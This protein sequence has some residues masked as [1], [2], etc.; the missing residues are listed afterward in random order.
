MEFSFLTVE[1][2][3]AIGWSLVHSIWQILVIA[4]VLKTVLLISRKN[5]P[6]LKFNFMLASLVFSLVSF[7]ITFFV[8]YTPAAV[9]TAVVNTSKLIVPNIVFASQPQSVL[10]TITSFIDAHVNTIVFIWLI[11]IM[12]Y[13]L[14]IVFGFLYVENI[15]RNSTPINDKTFIQLFEKLCQR[16]G[17]LRCVKVLESMTVKVPMVMGHLK[18]V[19]LLPAGLLTGMPYNQ[20]EAIMAHELAHI[21]RRDFLVNIIVVVIESLFFYHP[22]IWWITSAMDDEREKCCDDIAVKITGSKLIYAKALTSVIEKSIAKPQMALALSSNKQ[23]LYLRISRLLKDN[24]MKSNLREKMI[25]PIALLLVISTLAFASNVNKPNSTLQNALLDASANI[26]KQVDKEKE[27]YHYSFGL[28]DSTSLK[29][30]NGS[31][32]T[33]T[34]NSGFT[35]SRTGTYKCSSDNIVH[36]SESQNFVCIEGNS[37]G[38]SVMA[39]LD[40]DKLSHLEINSEIIDQKDYYKYK[41]VVDKCVK[42]ALAS[43][44]NR[45]V[46]PYRVNND[47]SFGSDNN[48]LNVQKTHTSTVGVTDGKKSSSSSSQLVKVIAKDDSNIVRKVSEDIEANNVIYIDDQSGSMVIKG[49]SF[50]VDSVDYFSNASQYTSITHKINDKN[51]LLVLNGSSV[52]KLKINGK[53]IPE[54]DYQKYKHLVDECIDK[55]DDIVK[56]EEK[57]SSLCELST[58]SDENIFYSSAHNDSYLYLNKTIKGERVKV[59]IDGNTVKKLEVNGKVIPESEYKNH[60][61]LIKECIE[62]SVMSEKEIRDVEK[63]LIDVKEDLSNTEI[64]LKEIEE[65]IEEAQISLNKD[66]KNI[67]LNLNITSE[68]DL[69]KLRKELERVKNIKVMSSGNSTNEEN[70]DID[71]EAIMSSVEFAMKNLDID[72]IVGD[73]TLS[74]DNVSEIKSNIDFNEISLSVKKA[75]KEINTDKIIVQVNNRNNKIKAIDIKELEKDI[76]KKAKK[77]K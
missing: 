71:V 1:F 56:E 4:I 30:A 63:D 51:V 31:S 74:L 16:I 17:I 61:K 65:D 26:D 75:G 53:V 50:S 55:S 22:A 6:S 34:Y 15:K 69:K 35:I 24:N 72:K 8:V 67:K 2:Q 41:K 38:Q 68:K 11:G 21:Y 52:V 60:K 3:K 54:S 66:L 47:D 40:G 49:N 29:G 7:V 77:K 73:V 10:A 45:I 14:K 59:A 12:L 46:V 39:I 5:T 44:K 13:I 57:K 32:S 9:N 20:I 18:P 28:R 33:I 37:D 70:I 25:L 27:K 23:K 42:K 64:D 76:D 48:E 36:T 58:D 19:L 43:E 62:L